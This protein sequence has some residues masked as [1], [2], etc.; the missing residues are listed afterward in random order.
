MK[1]KSFKMQNGKVLKY[2]NTQEDNLVKIIDKK[3]QDLEILEKLL[4]DGGELSKIYAEAFRLS[5]FDF[6]ADELNEYSDHDLF[7]DRNN[8]GYLHVPL[9]NIKRMLH[10][11][12]DSYQILTLEFIREVYL[13]SERNKKANEEGREKLSQEAIEKLD[14]TVL[15]ILEKWRRNYE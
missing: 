6:I 2:M 9:V 8:L 1:E 13:F 7:A 12:K 4:E 15:D 5:G 3:L 14:R 10:Y 11:I